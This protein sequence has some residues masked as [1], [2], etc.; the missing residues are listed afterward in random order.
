MYNK[1]H[2]IGKQS[3]ILYQMNKCNFTRIDIYRILHVEANTFKAY[4]NNP[5]MIPLKHIITMAGLF[6]LSPEELIYI[7]LRNKPQPIGQDNKHA[8]WYLENI[9]EKNK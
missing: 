2:N 5:L 4:I 1:S 8:S 7:I 6:G 9:K 3:P